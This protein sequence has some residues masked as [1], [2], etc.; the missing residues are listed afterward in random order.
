MKLLTLSLLTSF[1]LPSLALASFVNIGDPIVEKGNKICAYNYSVNKKNCIS[2]KEYRKTGG[3][4][5]DKEL[6]A[7]VGQE[8][9]S[10]DDTED[11]VL[12]SIDSAMRDN[13]NYQAKTA[14]EKALDDAEATVK[15]AEKKY[16]AQ[17]KKVERL[18]NQYNK[19]VGNSKIPQ[20]NPFNSAVSKAVTKK[21]IDTAGKNLKTAGNTH[22]EL[23]KE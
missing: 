8:L 14:H 21:A 2:F 4:L 18:K 10:D 16:R 20:N 5:S 3:E 9:D 6:N 13:L 17:E 7:Y 22:K 12:R 19:D 15:A 1:I 11:T 23:Q